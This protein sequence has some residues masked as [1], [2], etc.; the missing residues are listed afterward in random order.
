MPAHAP[1]HA[2][3]F[4]PPFFDAVATP[5]LMP[6]LL[7]IDFHHSSPRYFSPLFSFIFAAS[8][9]RYFFF[10]EFQIFRHFRLAFSPMPASH[11]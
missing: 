4:M 3:M 10:I 1:R 7:L 11:D 6:T 5:P 9:F 8:H 2:A